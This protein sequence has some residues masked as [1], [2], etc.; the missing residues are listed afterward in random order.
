MEDSGSRASDSAIPTATYVHV[1]GKPV[2][3]RCD[4]WPSSATRAARA[5]HSFGDRSLLRVLFAAG[6]GVVLRAEVGD[7]LVVPCQV[8]AELWVE[9]GFLEGAMQHIQYADWQ[10]ARAGQPIGRHRHDVEA[11]FAQ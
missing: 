8:F 7:L 6:V 3:E 11:K 2:R 10:S 1:R 5:L 9:Q 4:T